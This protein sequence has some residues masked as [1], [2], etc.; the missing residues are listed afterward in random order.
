[1]TH[2]EE[3]AVRVLPATV[4]QQ[5][6]QPGGLLRRAR[7]PTA[8]QQQAPP[9]AQH[10]LLQGGDE[11]LGQGQS[12]RLDRKPSV[13]EDLSH[14]KMDRDI[15]MADSGFNLSMNLLLFLFLFFFFSKNGLFLLDRFGTLIFCFVQAML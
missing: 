7:L 2:S 12:F 4:L 15:T 5:L 8:G 6:L 11:V 1:M 3:R 9:A 10:A 14:R 13:L